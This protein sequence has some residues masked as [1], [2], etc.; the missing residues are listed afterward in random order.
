MHLNVGGRGG[1]VVSVFEDQLAVD[2]RNENFVCRHGLNVL[3]SKQCDV[4][5]YRH[6]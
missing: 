5:K 1:H 3:E 4:R 6:V 2:K